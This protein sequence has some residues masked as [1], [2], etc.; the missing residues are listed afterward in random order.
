[1][2]RTPTVLISFKDLE[3]DPRI[4]ESIEKRCRHLAEEFQE[5]TRFE[6]TVAPDGLGYAVHGRATGKDT[7]TATHAE[8]S[9]LIQATD[10]LL[11]KLGRQLRRAHDKRIFG[12]RREAQRAHERRKSEE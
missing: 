6:V 2:A 10:R 9:E 1:M 7:E 8:A 3:A 11:D 5:T 4:R 12:H